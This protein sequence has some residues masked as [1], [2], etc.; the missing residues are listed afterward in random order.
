MVNLSPWK[1][2]TREDPEEVVCQACDTA[3][4]GSL[5]LVGLLGTTMTANCNKMQMQMA[6]EERISS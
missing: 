3:G 2:Q 1:S 6:S 5:L 4:C